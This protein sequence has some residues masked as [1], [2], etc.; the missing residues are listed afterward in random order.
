M[1]YWRLE[2]YQ[3]EGR[4]V[5][6]FAPDRRAVRPTGPTLVLLERLTPQQRDNILEHL[7]TVPGAVVLE[8]SWGV[9]IPNS[10][11][12]AVNIPAIIHL[13]LEDH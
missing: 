12:I 13:Y 9:E 8:H 10:F 11:E 4:T 3:H 2:T 7:K 5:I 6:Q 1:V